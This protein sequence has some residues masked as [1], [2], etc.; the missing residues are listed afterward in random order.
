MELFFIKYNK[1]KK[2]IE[3]ILE[4]E[5]RKV[6]FITEYSDGNFAYK[7]YIHRPVFTE[8]TFYV[9]DINKN[10]KY[11]LKSFGEYDNIFGSKFAFLT[12]GFVFS[13]SSLN[14]VEGFNFKKI[15]H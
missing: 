2:E 7:S 4:E 11:K 5:D 12:N 15:Y 9:F 3:I 13:T 1:S 8:D 14:I 6:E 10:E